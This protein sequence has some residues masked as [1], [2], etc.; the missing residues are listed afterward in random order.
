MISIAL[1]GGVAVALQ[2]Q[3]VGAMER[4]LGT[5]GSVFVTYGGGAILVTTCLMAT[6]NEVISKLEI[7]PIYLFSA[8]ALGLVVV[9]S[10]GYTVPR[11]GLA[12]VLT[13]VIASQLAV[14]LLIEQLGLFGA[15]A[16]QVELSRVFGMG[17]ILFGTWL[18]LRD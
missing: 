10:I 13:L 14:G 11:L 8:G 9:A 2:A 4:T 1:V 3:F 18:V 17:I 6:R 7:V 5:L 12:N 15:V 16:R